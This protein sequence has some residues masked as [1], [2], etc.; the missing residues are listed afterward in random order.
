MFS[1]KLLQLY[2]VSVATLYVG[3]CVADSS[4]QDPICL[5]K[6]PMLN[7][8]EEIK[9]VCPESESGQYQIL[10]IP[11]KEIHN[12][13]CNM[14]EL[15]GD[16]D[17]GWTRV[18]F[19]DMTNTSQKC[20]TGL[21]LYELNG[22]RA[23]GRYPSDGCQS[24]VFDIKSVKYSRVCGRV[25]GYQKGTPDAIVGDGDRSINDHYI[26]GVSI[27]RGNPR[28]H[29]WSFIGALY[30][31]SKFLGHRSTC[32]CS[33]AQNTPPFVGDHYYCESGN[34]RNYRTYEFFTED[35]LWDGKQ[36]GGLETDCCDVPGLPWFHRILEERTNDDI[37][38]RIC[39]NSNIANEDTP[40]GSYE[41]YVK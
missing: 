23:C 21:K 32:P 6:L 8:C 1:F 33:N 27:T 26:D 19:L 14:G 10:D 36:C 24:V 12:V 40:V 9:S 29:L 16:Q 28:Q 7:S 17:G 4:N 39:G 2:Y 5:L 18:G 11:N 15:C 35:V 41:I 37:E 3:M 25:Y 31:R 34:P 13:Y 22:I 38:L 20:P 30:E